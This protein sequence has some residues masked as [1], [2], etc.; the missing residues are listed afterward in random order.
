MADKMQN[1][2][3]DIVPSSFFTSPNSYLNS[4]MSLSEMFL[5]P[6]DNININQLNQTKVLNKLENY[7][8]VSLITDSLSY[9]F[10]LQYNEYSYWNY[11]Y[12][13]NNKTWQKLSNSNHPRL[14]FTG[15]LDY[16]VPFQTIDYWRFLRE[17]N[18]SN[19][20]WNIVEFP[21]VGHTPMSLIIDNIT[22]SFD[23]FNEFVDAIINK[24]YNQNGIDTSCAQN[25]PKTF[26]FQGITQETIMASEYLFGTAN[27]WGD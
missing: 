3:F 14:I 24:T 4:Y 5:G 12:T 17:G 18:S 1:G 6:N 22:C 11:L 13:P 26:D 25:M 21:L 19:N 15:D 23:I 2:W 8:K 10:A 9:Q 27:V 20:L 16:S 7:A